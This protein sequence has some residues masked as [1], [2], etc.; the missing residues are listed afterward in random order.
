[1]AE[2]LAVGSGNDGISVGDKFP[3]AAKVASHVISDLQ[4]ELVK[5][6]DGLEDEEE[7]E[8]TME[9]EEILKTCSGIQTNHEKEVECRDEKAAKGK[10]IHEMLI[11]LISF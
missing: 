8:L 6:N 5:V 3:E 7:E 10:S 9:L 4:L 1:M 11:G 2:I